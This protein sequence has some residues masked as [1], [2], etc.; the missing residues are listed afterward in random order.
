MPQNI[1]I[2]ARIHTVESLIQSAERIS[3]EGPI[4]IH[5]DDIFFPCLNGRLKL[6][7]FPD[8]TADLIFYQRPDKTGPKTSDYIIYRTQN[9]DTLRKTLAMAHGESGRVTK[10][11]LLFLSGRTRIHI[12]DVHNLGHFVEL[13]VVL[14]D[15]DSYEGGV[16]EANELMKKLNISEGDLIEN[17]YIDLI[18]AAQ[19]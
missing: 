5:Q 15:G 7:I 12:D 6:R 9:S 8:A 14:A 17:A 19:S 11:R 16:R 18:E 3:D 4:T 1:E 13:E 2:K 10:K